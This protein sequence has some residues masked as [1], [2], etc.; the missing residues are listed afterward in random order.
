MA[1][2][3]SKI[4]QTKGRKKTAM[5]RLSLRPGKGRVKLNGE[6]LENFK[7]EVAREVIME[8]VI[9]AENVLGKDQMAGVDVDINTYGGGVMGQ[10][11]ACRTALGK[12]LVKFSNSDNLK[13]A[14]LEYD[15][16]LLID[17]V[18]KKE[19]KKCLRLGARAKPTK[20]YR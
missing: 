18:R 9:I 10:A 17:D 12:A 2:K 19:P 11:Y 16:S 3:K 8:P 13:N 5:A 14:F 4:I 7:P 15:R 1:T 20:S 6:L